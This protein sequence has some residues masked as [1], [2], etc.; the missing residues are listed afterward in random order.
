MDRGLARGRRPSA[1]ASRCGTWHNSG[2]GLPASVQT[3]I[4]SYLPPLLA[5][6]VC[7]EWRD[8]VEH[9]WATLH[10]LRE[11]LQS[12]DLC[13]ESPLLCCPGPAENPAVREW[14]AKN[15]KWQEGTCFVPLFELDGDTLQAVTD[16]WEPP[17]QHHFVKIIAISS[18]DKLRAWMQVQAECVSDGRQELSM[19]LRLLMHR[20]M[21]FTDV[22]TECAPGPH[23]TYRYAAQ[24]AALLWQCKS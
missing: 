3:N 23:S 11:L 4:E 10:A 16:L 14:A 8:N 22:Y 12:L 5:R 20:G 17:H 21:S 13:D 19:V 7:R 24:I 2:K 18:L 1:D 9:D 15:F 6:A